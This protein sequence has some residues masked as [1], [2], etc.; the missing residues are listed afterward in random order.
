MWAKVVQTRAKVVQNG[1][2][3]SKDGKNVIAVVVDHHREEYVSRW[4]IVK[5]ACC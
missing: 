4:E 5:A 1:V 3:T 2:I